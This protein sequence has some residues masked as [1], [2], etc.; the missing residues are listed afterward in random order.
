MERST[1]QRLRYRRSDRPSW[2]ADERDFAFADRSAQSRDVANASAT[3]RCRTICRQSPAQVSAGVGPHS[4]VALPGSR[5]ASLPRAGLPP[6]MQSECGLPKEHPRRRPPPFTSSPCPAWFFRL[7]S[8]LFW[9]SK[10]AVRKRLASL[11]RVAFFRNTRQIFSQTAYSSQSRNRR[12]KVE[13]CGNFSGRS[14][15]RAPHR[16]IHRIPSSIRRFSIHGRPTLHC[17][18]GRGSKGAIFFR[19]ASV[20]NAADRAIRPPSALLTLL[21]SHFQEFNDRHFNALSM[22]VQKLLSTL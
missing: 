14:C 5:R 13:G 6:G 17:L 11:Q 22:V 16:R 19:C 4:G 18:G 3:D 15:Q 1:I 10:T 9:Q 2:V 12:Q 8:P 7:R 20:S 21:I